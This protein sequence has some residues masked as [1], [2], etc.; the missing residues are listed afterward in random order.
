MYVQSAP[1]W[2]SSPTMEVLKIGNKNPPGHRCNLLFAN[3]EWLNDGDEK[4]PSKLGL[5]DQMLGM[6]IRATPFSLEGIT[7]QY[8]IWVQLTHTT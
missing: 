5:R 2:T 3:G 1:V 4:A 6:V 7:T 8:D